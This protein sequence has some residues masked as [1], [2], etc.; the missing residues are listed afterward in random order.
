METALLVGRL[1]LAA[2]FLIAGFAKLADRQGTRQAMVD[3][4]VPRVL[5]A[6]IGILLPLVEIAI[7][8]ALIPAASAWW[9]A[10]GALALLLL[11]VLGI[12]V[13]LALGRRPDCRCFGQLH[14][15]PAGWRTL[16]RDG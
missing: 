8:V 16:V 2:V 5:A 9:G 6:P 11:F 3:F 14:S 7:G 15:A 10:I 12:G 13:N 1:G 4:G